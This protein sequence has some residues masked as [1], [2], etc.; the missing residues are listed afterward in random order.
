MLHRLQRVGAQAIA[1][2]WPDMQAPRTPSLT[3]NWLEVAAGRLK[4]WKGSSARARAHRALEFIKA[5]YPG[6]DLDRLATLWSEA[7]PELAAAE[8]A[9]VK[10]AAVIAE[11]T[12][13]SIFVPEWSED[14]E[15]VPPE[16]FGLNP[17]YDKDSAEVIG[18]SVEEEDEAEDEGEAEA[19]EDG[20][21]GQ[22]QPDRASSNEPRATDPIAAGRDQAETSR[23]TALTTDAGASSDPPTPAAAS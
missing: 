14:G 12:D 2:L 6:L 11:Y 3:A 10:R 18:S 21:D 19:P 4:A 7:Q 15:E 5:W 1:A 17:D 16:W 23:P 8:D 13:M 20:A 9:L 22:P